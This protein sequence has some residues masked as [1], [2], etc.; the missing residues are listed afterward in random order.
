MEE[1]FEPG[2]IVFFGEQHQQGEIVSKN[3]DDTYVIEYFNTQGSLRTV[4]V[5]SEHIFTE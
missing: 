3:A 5:S 2:D 4:T 1:D